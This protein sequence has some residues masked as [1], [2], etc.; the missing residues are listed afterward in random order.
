M[1]VWR[2]HTDASKNLIGM[3]KFQRSRCMRRG[4]ENKDFHHL[5]YKVVK[6]LNSNLFSRE[7][8][9]TAPVLGPPVVHRSS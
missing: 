4:S 7:G 2:S 9:N 5:D 1:E 3:N 6:V 8:D